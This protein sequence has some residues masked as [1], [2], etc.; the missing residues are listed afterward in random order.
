MVYIEDLLI[1]YLMPLIVQALPLQFSCATPLL[2]ATFTKQG[3]NVKTVENKTVTHSLRPA[4]ES[5]A[6]KLQLHLTRNSLVLKVEKKSIF[7]RPQSSCDV[8]SKMCRLQFC[9]QNLLFPKSSGIYC[10]IFVCMVGL[11]VTFFTV[12]NCPGIV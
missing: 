11:S 12:S 7:I 4:Q 5:N 2:W 3:S 1:P 10:T 9:F 8:V 6:K